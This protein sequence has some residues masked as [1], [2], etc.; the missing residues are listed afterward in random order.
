[1]V[2]LKEEKAANRNAS[3]IIAFVENVFPL[4]CIKEQAEEEGMG[5]KK[6]AKESEKK[7]GQ[8]V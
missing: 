2:Q 3:T 4:Q 6:T 1:M 8:Q 5:L 7:E